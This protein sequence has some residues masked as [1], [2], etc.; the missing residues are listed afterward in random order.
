MKVSVLKPY[1]L[2]ENGNYEF[3]IQDIEGYTVVLTSPL[4]T[5]RRSE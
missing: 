3:G 1:R 2:S 4:Q 5:S